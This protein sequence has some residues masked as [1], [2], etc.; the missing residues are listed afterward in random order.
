M[1]YGVG[2]GFDVSSLDKRASL[3]L[4]AICNPQ[5]IDRVKTAIRE[6]VDRLLRDGVTQDELEKAKQG[7]FE[8]QK[9]RRT[10][11]GALAGRLADLSHAG[12]TMEYYADLEKKIAALTP[13][14][15][16]A[17]A[18]KHFDPKNLVIVTAGDFEATTAAS[19]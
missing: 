13:E 4:S 1:S 9:V 3:S 6:E 14:Q 7:Y 15:V 2:S 10:T 16:L 17:A 5:N 18:R 11:D 12:R 8:A 19:R